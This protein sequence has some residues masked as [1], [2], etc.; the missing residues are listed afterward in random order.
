MLAESIALCV[1]ESALSVRIAWRKLENST[2]GAD[3]RVN[4]CAFSNHFTGRGRHSPAVR[5]KLFLRK[6]LGL[7][8]ADRA[9]DWYIME[10]RNAEDLGT[11]R[12]GLRP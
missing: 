11:F 2:G 9:V 10:E 12:R 1:P 5:R 7:R 8:L 4:S 6:S 3:P